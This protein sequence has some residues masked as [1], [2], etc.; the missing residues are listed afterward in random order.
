MWEEKFS[1]KNFFFHE[2]REIEK[3]FFSRNAKCEISHFFSFLC[4]HSE[5]CFSFK[6]CKYDRC[7]EKLKEFHKA[8]ETEIDDCKNL[9]K[10][11]SFE[12]QICLNEN[13]EKNWFFVVVFEI[14]KSF[15]KNV[16]F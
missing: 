3:K 6:K 8:D 7:N 2:R 14:S 13:K 16:E 1:Q 10:T 11:Y 9:K 4:D 5:R 12:T 15:R